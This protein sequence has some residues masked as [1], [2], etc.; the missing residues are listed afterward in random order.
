MPRSTLAGVAGQR[1]CAI[2]V[3]SVALLGVGCSS[4]SPTT[5][6]APIGSS[7]VP[8]PSSTAPGRVRDGVLRIGVLLPSTGAGAPIGQSALAAVKVAVDLANGGGGVNGHPVQ[9]FVRDEGDNASAAATGV[10]Q[11]LRSPH[12]PQH[13]PQT[14]TEAIGRA[15]RK[16][17]AWQC[18][19]WERCGRTVHGRTLAWMTRSRLA[20]T[21]SKSAAPRLG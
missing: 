8:V 20:R 18:P 14:L 1:M 17:C 4:S 13:S 21:C 15:C 2:T 16:V 12:F 3:M 6:S 7:I 11:L 9:L 5:A 19:T 10:Q